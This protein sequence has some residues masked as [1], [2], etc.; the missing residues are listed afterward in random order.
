MSTE[1]LE[2]LEKDALPDS[3][4]LGEMRRRMERAEE[5]MAEASRNLSRLRDEHNA[6]TSWL[7]HA[8][9]ET[10]TPE[11]FAKKTAREVLLSRALAEAKLEHQQAINSQQGAQTRFDREYNNYLFKLRRLR[12][13]V[14]SSGHMLTTAE[15]QQDRED[16]R[17]MIGA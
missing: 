5:N 16:V 1:L 2:T 8:T 10:C 13:R 9:L 4:P 15:L 14:D 7:A 3:C 17:R 6:L 12:E 11:E